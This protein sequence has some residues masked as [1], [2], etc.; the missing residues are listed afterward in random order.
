MVLMRMVSHLAGLSSDPGLINVLRRLQPMSE[1]LNG[2][3]TSR[4]ITTFERELLQSSPTKVIVSNQSPSTIGIFGSTFL[5][6]LTLDLPMYA[7]L[8]TCSALS[9]ADLVKKVLKLQS[10]VQEIKIFELSQGS[11]IVGHLD[12][13]QNAPSGYKV[14]WKVL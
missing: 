7:R 10:S 12:L 14:N 13:R 9:S 11:I 2:L 4:E 5:E 3:V 6:C 8:T 1:L